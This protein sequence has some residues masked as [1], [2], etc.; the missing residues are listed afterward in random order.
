MAEEA[1]KA[2][3]QKKEKKDIVKLLMII[4]QLITLL[5]VVGMF[6]YFKFFFTIPTVHTKNVLE[7][8]NVV[9]EATKPKQAVVKLEPF[10]VN[11]LDEGGRRFLKVTIDLVVESE[12]VSKEVQER[13]PEIRDLIIMCLSD[14]SFNEISDQTG[15]MRL[16]KELR[17]KLNN[18]LKKG[19]VNKVL[20]TEFVVQ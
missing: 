13:L 10:V 20:F 8:A 12:E 15:K 14:K 17:L 6:V 5:L 4:T 18:L 2:E 7:E 3:E 9:K 16:R 19:R 1:P 11:L